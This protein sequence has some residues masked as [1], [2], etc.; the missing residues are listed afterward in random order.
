MGSLRASLPSTFL[1]FLI[2]NIKTLE[3]F[4]GPS[5]LLIY[6]KD[7]KNYKY[8]FNPNWH[9]GHSQYLIPSQ[10]FMIK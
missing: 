5:V 9:S 6:K 3:V 2:M 4:R 10:S 8:S 1:Y 7:I